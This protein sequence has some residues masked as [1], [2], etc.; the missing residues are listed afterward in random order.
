MTTRRLLVVAALA[1]A[2]LLGVG[3]WV[4]LRWYQHALTPAAAA[5]EE[6]LFRVRPGDSARAVG[7]R[8]AEAGLAR[9]ARAFRLRA[10]QTGRVPRA[11]AYVVSPAMSIDELQELFASGRTAER[12]VTF[13]EGFGLRQCA[14]RA[15]KAE[16]C[17]AQA[18]L[19]AA[20]GAAPE[21]AGLGL[22]K[23][24]TLEGYL[25]PDTYIVEPPTTAEALVA[26]QLKRFDEVWRDIDGDRLLAGRTRH[27]VVTMASLIEREARG[28]D[29][30]ARIAG[31][32]ANR[33]RRG[34]RLQI[35][36]TVLYALGRH[37]QRVL[38]SDLRVDSPY[39]TYR[40]KGLPPGPICCPGKPSLV[41]ALRPERH[42]YLFYV[43]GAGNKHVFTRTDAEHN[44][45]K[46]AAR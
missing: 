41:A 7:E 44:R 31:V 24:A 39:N 21:A 17:S 43:L 29:E 2:L 18:Y 38:Y 26:M 10:R 16:I 40:V 35:D 4:A 23:R 25:F 28:D 15:E 46:E 9:N 42:D 13:P 32:I 8:L 30:R 11:G 34:M 1:V 3:P 19:A 27:Q 14:E 22:A 12:K 20:T 45:A 33:L 36:A 6:R 37:K 5:G